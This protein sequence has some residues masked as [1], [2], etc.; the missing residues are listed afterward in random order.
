MKF[1]YI[2]GVENEL[3]DEVNETIETLKNTEIKIWMLSYYNFRIKSKIKNY[4]I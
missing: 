1:L 2:T 4:F 3:Q